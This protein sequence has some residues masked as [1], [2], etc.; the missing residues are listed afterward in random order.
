MDDAQIAAKY[1]AEFRRCLLEL[2][3]AGVIKLHQHVSPHLPVPTKE[4]A[5]VSLHQAR[6]IARSVPEKLRIYSRA[7]LD[8]RARAAREPLVKESVGYATN[9][10]DTVLRSALIGGVSRTVDA[11]LVGGVAPS[12]AKT[13]HPLMLDAR[14]KVKSGRV[15][16]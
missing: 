4:Q 12:D 2:D 16:V 1:G 7:W 3:V 8:E 11:A 15:S 6:T 9:T 10:K 5:L 13:L 14:A